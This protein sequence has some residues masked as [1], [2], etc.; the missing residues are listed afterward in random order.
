MDLHIGQEVVCIDA[1]NYVNNGLMDI[2][3]KGKV[4]IVDRLDFEDGI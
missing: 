2:L 3:E 4:Y 1:S